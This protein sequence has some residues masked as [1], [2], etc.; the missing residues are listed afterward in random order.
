MG[1]S[2][3]RLAD[4]TEPPTQPAVSSSSL[5]SSRLLEGVVP[6]W[7]WGGA[8]TGQVGAQVPGHSPTQ[9]LT[10]NAVVLIA[11][12]FSGEGVW[13]PPVLLCPGLSLPL[14]QGVKSLL[15]PVCR[16]SQWPRLGQGSQNLLAKLPR[17]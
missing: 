7:G 9:A 16:W 11:P 6:H 4:V 13:G 10:G 1:R 14:W 15:C 2:G 12:V 5:S 8:G 3:G 17:G